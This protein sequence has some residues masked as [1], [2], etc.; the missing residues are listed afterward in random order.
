[1]SEPTFVPGE[2]AE[3]CDTRPMFLVRRRRDFCTLRTDWSN[4][5]RLPGDRNVGLFRTRDEADRIARAMSVGELPARPTDNPFLYYADGFDGGEECQTLIDVPED[6]FV[7][8]VCGLGLP[9]PELHPMFVPDEYGEREPPVGRYA[10]AEWYDRLAPT[11]TDQQ[12]MT[13]WQRFGGLYFFEVIEV[14]LFFP[15]GEP[16][17]F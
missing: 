9:A 15:P 4:H 17:P 7:A 10:W 3:D 11:L 6:D 2:L 13:I 1:M 5:R 8:F 16:A 14:Q 12:R